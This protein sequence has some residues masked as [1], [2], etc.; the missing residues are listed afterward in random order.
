[1]VIFLNHYPEMRIGKAKRM[2]DETLATVNKMILLLFAVAVMLVTTNAQAYVSLNPAVTPNINCAQGVVGSYGFWTSI[3]GGT[4]PFAATGGGINPVCDILSRLNDIIRG[5]TGKALGTIAIAALGIAALFGKVSWTTAMLVVVGVAMIFGAGSVMGYIGLQPLSNPDVNPISAVLDTL[6]FSMTREAGRAVAVICIVILGIGALFGKVSWIQALTLAT[7]IGVAFGAATIVTDVWAPNIAD[8]TAML[9]TT[10]TDAVGGPFES[11][12]LFLTG[13]AGVSIATAL[14]MC[15]GFAAML[16]K[17]TWA[18]AILLAVG[19]SL[20]FGAA[21]VVYILSGPLTLCSLTPLTSDSFDYVICAFMEEIQGPVGKTLTTM[22]VILT[23]ILAMLGKVSW[24]LGFIL[25]IG[26]A[27]IFGADTIV[28]MFEVSLTGVTCASGAP[29]APSTGN[30]IADVLCYI[31]LILYGPAGKALAT[32]AVIMVGFG[33]LLGKASFGQAAIVATGIAVCF[34][35][36]TIV[37]HL[38]PSAVLTGCNTSTG[39]AFGN[40]PSGLPGTC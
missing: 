19:I 21:D 35:A 16:G 5:T 40:F 13:P 12:I 37:G 24:E 29:S 33:A 8:D 38:M 10:A 18:Q 25:M 30:A 6:T 20:M 17:V 23:G 22:A 28:E 31:V 1:M 2:K 36:P 15:L 11:L 34:G 39:G 27:I 32:I 4:N 26:I 14:L 7:G 3:F 9:L